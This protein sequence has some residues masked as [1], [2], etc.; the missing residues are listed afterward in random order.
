MSNRSELAVDTFTSWQV[1]CAPKT[2]L[3]KGSLTE[4]LTR[5]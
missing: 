4:M 5:I 2:I 3:A 1:G